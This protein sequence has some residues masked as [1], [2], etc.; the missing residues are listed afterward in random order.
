MFI[1][2]SISVPMHCALYLYLGYLTDLGLSHIFKQSHEYMPNT[3]VH[4]LCHQGIG[5]F[6]EREK[7]KKT[8]PRYL[9]LA[10]Y[11]TTRWLCSQLP[12]T[13]WPFTAWLL[14]HHSLFR[15]MNKNWEKYS[16]LCLSPFQ[17]CIHIHLHKTS[18]TSKCKLGTLKLL[19]LKLLNFIHVLL[20]ASSHI[21][22]S[23]ILASRTA[24]P[25]VTVIRTK[26]WT[27]W[28]R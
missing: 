19:K 21:M 14:G 18:I 1:P 9:L 24:T 3:A 28:R 2:F 26:H 25:N 5:L 12:P 15:L 23:L 7:K 20:C 13:E 6:R 8:F 22:V 16:N 27:K 10:L 17:S 4:I 11:S